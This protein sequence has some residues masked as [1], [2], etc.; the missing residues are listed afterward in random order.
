MATILELVEDIRNAAAGGEQKLAMLMCPAVGSSTAPSGYARLSKCITDECRNCG[1]PV[2]R[3]P[4]EKITDEVEL[5]PVCQFCTKTVIEHAE[6]TCGI[7]MTP[8]IMDRQN[9]REVVR[10]M[11]KLKAGGYN[12]QDEDYRKATAAYDERRVIK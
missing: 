5:V 2:W 3:R 9:E 12:A 11:Q 1:R 7:N 6:E 10:K 8:G 4:V